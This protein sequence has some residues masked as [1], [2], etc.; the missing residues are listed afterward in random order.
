MEAEAAGRVS[1]L[2]QSAVAA[3]YFATAKATTG[4]NALSQRP[5]PLIL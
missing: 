3:R 2:A 1:P 4:A 5:S